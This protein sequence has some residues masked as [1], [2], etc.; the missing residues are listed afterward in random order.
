MLNVHASGGQAMMR[1]AREAADQE[2]ARSSRPAPI[3]IAV[4]TLTSLSG[5]MLGEI[6]VAGDLTAQVERLAALTLSAG[7]DG[8]VASPHEVALI[9]AR[10]GKEFTIV[11][12]GIRGAGDAK[13]DQRRTMS[14]P[15]A[16]AA[17]ATYLVIGRPI[18][19]A[20]DPCAAAER[21]VAECG[22]AS[23]PTSR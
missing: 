15:E 13:G 17:G 16:L 1:A 11:T 5:Q 3:V 19:A 10:C 4:T 23:P 7:L 20:P 9:R 21:I 6:G 8:V 22:A 18:I 2:A 14:A 12:P